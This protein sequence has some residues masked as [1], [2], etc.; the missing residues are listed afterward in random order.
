LHKNGA[1]AL[2][3]FQFDKAVAKSAELIL[4]VPRKADFLLQAMAHVAES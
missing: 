1:A 4:R 2:M 3:L